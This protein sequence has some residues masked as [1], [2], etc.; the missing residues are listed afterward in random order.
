LVQAAWIHLS[1]PRKLHLEC[2]LWIRRSTGQLCVDL[3]PGGIWPPGLCL[4]NNYQLV[5]E[6]L[7]LDP[8][9]Q[10]ATV[11]DSLSLVECHIICCHILCGIQ[12]ISFSLP[13]TLNLGAVFT[14]SPGRQFEDLVEIASLPDAEHN[15]LASYWKMWNRA[16]E[17]FRTKDGWSCLTSYDVLDGRIQLSLSV[18][19]NDPWLSQANYIFSRLGIS[20]DCQDYVM[21]RSIEFTFS[22]SSTT[23]DRPKGFL[24]ICPPQDFRCGPLSFRWPEIPFYWSLDSS[25]TTRLS[26]EDAAH[27]GFPS[28]ELS[29]EITGRSWSA[30]VYAGLRKFHEAKGFNPDSQDIARHLGQPLYQLTAEVDTFF[31]HVDT[32]DCSVNRTEP[33]RHHDEMPAVSQTFIFLMQVQLGL[34]VF[35]VLHSMYEHIW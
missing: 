32:E 6:P 11:I 24:F 31:A 14:C 34:I 9:T 16:P 21:P 20:S 28:I 26:M 4:H 5:L 7:S 1:F 22:I 30:R 3:T 12:P 33:S 10:E 35:L 23:P 8:P 17:P 25:G 27:L 18:G 13:L 29:R 15:W 2:I 19:H